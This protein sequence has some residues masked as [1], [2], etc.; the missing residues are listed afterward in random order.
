MFKKIALL[1]SVA[2]PL[3]IGQSFANWESF[4]EID[5][6]EDGQ[7]IHA[8]WKNPAG[9]RRFFLSSAELESLESYKGV[10]AALPI[11]EGYP[12]EE[13]SEGRFMLQ[14]TN[15]Q[16]AKNPYHLYSLF[17]Q[18]DGSDKI[19]LGFI[20][21]G[22]MPSRGYAEGSEAHP[23]AHHPII[24]KWISLGITRQ[25]DSE[26][27]VNDANLERI[28]NRG[29]AMI[30]PLFTSEISQED[31]AGAVEAAYELVCKFTER[32]KTL[33]V[34]GTLPYMAVSLFHPSD[35][36]IGAFQASSFTADADEGFGWFYPKDGVPQFRTLVTRPVE[37]EEEGLS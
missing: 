2:F 18:V 20:Q 23:T 24:Q 29:L 37:V 14:N 8:V 12:A 21:F 5:T 3:S 26:G 6:E 28:Q 17:S 25:I 31:R 32:K 9:D 22:R 36:N 1:V 7:R 19:S 15:R 30:L 4:E 34:E 27:G 11:K 13:G 33:P 35:P 16:G 10:L